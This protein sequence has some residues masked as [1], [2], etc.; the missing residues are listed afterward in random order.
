MNCYISRIL[1]L[2]D[3]A[4]VNLCANKSMALI[5]KLRLCLSAS[6]FVLLLL[7]QWNLPWC[8]LN[9]EVAPIGF[10]G[11]RSIICICKKLWSRH[12]LDNFFFY[13]KTTILLQCNC[14]SIVLIYSSVRI[15][16]NVWMCTMAICFSS[17]DAPADTCV[18]FP[19]NLEISRLGQTFCLV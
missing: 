14:K 16:Q 3:T 17:L 11:L 19:V 6:S 8:I 4:S 10:S 13:R 2:Y 1:H 5:K 7:V 12:Q 9:I 15:S 18:H